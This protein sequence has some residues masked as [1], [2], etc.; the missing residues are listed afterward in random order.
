MPLPGHESIGWCGEQGGRFGPELFNQGT[1]ALGRHQWLV[2]CS[3]DTDHH[4]RSVV[5]RG[6]KL[7]YFSCDFPH[8]RTI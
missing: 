6:L 8:G 4:Q 3:V 2:G 1:D 5:R 7:Y